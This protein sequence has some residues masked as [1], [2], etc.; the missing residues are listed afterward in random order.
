MSRSCN[1]QPY[2]WTMN[3]SES[4]Q[5]IVDIDG[6]AFRM[7]SGTA[8][9][10]A[11]P[12]E[13]QGNKWILTDFNGTMARFMTVEAPLRYA[14]VVA[15]RRLLETGD[16]QEHARLL[17]HWKRARG[18][19]SSELYFTVA[20]AER[21]RVYEDRA[22]DDPDHHLLFSVHALLYVCLR[23][24]AKDPIIAVLFEHDRHVDILI[25]RS[26][27]VLAASRVSS[28]GNSR[29][30]KENHAETVSQEILALLIGAQIKLD[31]IVYFSWL[32]GSDSD[33]AAQQ[34]EQQ[35]L[36]AAAWVEQ[37]GRILHNTP[38]DLVPAQ[39]L[40]RPDQGFIVT[41][42]PTLLNGLKVADSSSPT[43]D[44]LQYQAQGMLPRL[45]PVALLVTIVLFFI[46][47]WFNTKAGLLNSEA[48][49][50]DQELATS[51][52]KPAPPDA[53][54][55]RMVSFVDG[56]ARL[57]V[58]PTIQQLLKELHDSLDGRRITFEHLTIEQDDQARIQMALKGIIQEPFPKASQDYEALIDRLREHHFRVQKS[59]LTTDVSELRFILK[60]ERE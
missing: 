11:D 10:I 2:G 35:R 32:H 16:A 29:E 9:P 59:E 26:G 56:L 36:Q 8:Q 7:G 60:L 19:T 43:N 54:L 30:A 5:W 18:K 51:S 48:K 27:Q 15:Q 47:I 55:T 1:G 46:G 12:S 6:M 17:T 49:R 38:F 34:A 52:T 31:R 14:E 21:I 44:R 25:G 42:L 39:I 40:Q 24:Q 28:Y 37:L 33:P 50:L 20:E 4:D 53:T 3:I 58:A 22:H 13:I 41:A 45:L 23:Q 57:Q